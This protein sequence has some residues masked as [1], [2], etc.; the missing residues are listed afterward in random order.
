[1]LLDALLIAGAYLLGSVSTAVIV[2]RAFGHQ[3]PRAT[4]SGNPGATNV[5]RSA[6]KAAALLTL[7]GD[8][9][10]GLIPVLAGKA[11][12]VAAPTLALIACAAFAGH[13]F[14]LFFGF[15]GG[16]GVATYIGVLL[17]VSV[18]L[19]V[20]FGLIWLL[21]AALSRYSSLAALTAAASSPVI[22]AWLDQPSPIV[23]ASLAITVVLAARHRGN[24]QRLLAGEESR[25]GQRRAR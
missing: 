7:V 3:D 25:I 21:V 17:G 22:A 15:R 19:G 12:I 2:C 11:L 14:P 6:G 13:I 16:K 23:G 9:A 18:W 4:G 20:A 24:I 1:M 5:L 8:V 10:K